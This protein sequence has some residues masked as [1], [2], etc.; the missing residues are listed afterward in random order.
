M[1]KNYL[2]IFFRLTIPKKNL[3]WQLILYLTI[4]RKFIKKKTL[5]K[6][7]TSRYYIDYNFPRSNIRGLTSNF[8]ISMKK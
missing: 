3:I 4:F 6:Y 2:H 8:F 7:K 1:M 5:S